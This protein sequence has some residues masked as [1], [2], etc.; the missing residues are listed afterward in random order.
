ML[1]LAFAPLSKFSIDST[2]CAE[3]PIYWAISFSAATSSGLTM[4]SAFA[5]MTR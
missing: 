5:M 4:P 3:S 2:S 1:L